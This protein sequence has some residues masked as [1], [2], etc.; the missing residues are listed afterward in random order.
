MPADAERPGGS[1]QPVKE[2][3]FDFIKGQYFRVIHADGVIGGP[4]PQGHLHFAFY[5]ERPPIPRRLVQPISPTGRLE[6]PIL[7]KS[8]IRDALV[9]EV[10]IDVIMTVQVAEQF[11]HWLTARLEEMRAV[12]K[13][14]EK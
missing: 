13:E 14:N 7:E 4:T 6:D 2:V 3:A 11:H 10:D 9:R 5:S 12:M 1:G 8:V